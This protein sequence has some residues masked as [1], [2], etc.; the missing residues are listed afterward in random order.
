MTR[1]IQKQTILELKDVCHIYHYEKYSLFDRLNIVINNGDKCG[2]LFRHTEGKTTLAKLMCGIVTPSNGK[3]LLQGE[4]IEKGDNGVAVL[5]ND[6][7]LLKNKNALQNLEYVLKIRKISG[8]KQL[9]KD[10][11]AKWGLEEKS[12]LPVK[13]L[14]GLDKL[15]VALA[16][17]SLRQPKLIVVDGVFSWLDGQERQI[18]QEFLLECNTVVVIDDNIDNLSFCKNIF[19]LKDKHT[20]FEGDF[21]TAVGYEKQEKEKEN[22]L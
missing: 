14:C 13:K 12:K 3:V 6:L 8:S 18:L 4:S 5:W 19:I 22:D 7:A 11:L 1:D 17:I 20:V 16:R 10:M 15:K 2:I 9:A 21:P